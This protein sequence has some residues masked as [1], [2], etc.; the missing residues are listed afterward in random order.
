[1]VETWFAPAER[2]ERKE[3]EREMAR[4]SVNP[5]MDF[6]LKSVGGLVVILNQRRQIIAVNDV[7]L[8]ELG[9]DDPAGVFGLRLGEAIGCVHAEE[10]PAGCGT[11]R[12]C[13]TCGAAIAMVTSLA[14]NG[15]VTEVC[16]AVTRD[17]DGNH[18]DLYFQVRAVP[19]S[20]D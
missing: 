18:R 8:H 10:K 15:P 13:R 9:V 14:E 4:V 16:S 3:L 1:M 7:F 20:S 2:S 5:V 19:F 11:T 12:Y 17:R 6:V